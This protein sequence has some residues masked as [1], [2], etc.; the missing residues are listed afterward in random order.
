[1]VRE[2]Q[3]YSEL[4]YNYLV[5]EG[6][7]CYDQLSDKELNPSIRKNYNYIRGGVR[8]AFANLM[9]HLFSDNHYEF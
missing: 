1:M 6:I 9:Q 4:I 3:E 7:D 5:E 8:M 2:H